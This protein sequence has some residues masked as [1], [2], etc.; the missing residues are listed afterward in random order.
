MR[1]CGYPKMDRMAGISRR[2]DRVKTVLICPHHTLARGKDEIL[3]ISTFLKFA[4]FFLR[5]PT[6]FPDMRFVFRPHPLLFPRLETDEWWGRQKADD[7]RAALEAQPNVEFQQ[8]GDYFETFVNSD[9]MVHDCGSFMAEYFY[10]GHPQ[11]YLLEAPGALD[12]Q[13]TPFGKRLQEHVAHA[14]T[15]DEIVDFVRRVAEGRVTMADDPAWRDFATREVCV[16]HPH[17]AS[18]VVSEIDRAL[19]EVQR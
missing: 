1:S 11:C 2:R 10:A 12:A 16:A 19:K 6:I 13:L 18:E 5:L 15:E 3:A 7:Y 17:A 14:C 4:D 9:A 8:G